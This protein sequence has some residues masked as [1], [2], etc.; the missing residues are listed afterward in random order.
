MLTKKLRAGAAALIF[1]GATLYAA[2]AYAHGARD[3]AIIEYHY[4]A[5]GPYVYTVPYAQHLHYC[6]AHYEYTTSNGASL[7]LAYTQTTEFNE[8]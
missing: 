5:M 2:S 1:A 4:V 6:D 3:Y 7:G 8:C